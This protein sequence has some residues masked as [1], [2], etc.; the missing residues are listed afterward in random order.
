LSKSSREPNP[1]LPI[2]S[3]LASDNELMAVANLLI[4]CLVNPS[5]EAFEDFCFLDY[6]NKEKKN[7]YSTKNRKRRKINKYLS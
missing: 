6:I 7:I 1:Y 5:D 3:F 4:D 2:T